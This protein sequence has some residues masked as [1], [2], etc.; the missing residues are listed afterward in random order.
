MNHS[1]VEVGTRRARDGRM[2]N[3]SCTLTYLGWSGFLLRFSRSRP[4][5]FDPPQEAAIPRDEDVCLLVTHGHPEHIAGT[6]AYLRSKTRKGSAEVFASPRI[7][8]ALK[9]RSRNEHDVFHPCRPEQTHGMAGITVNVFQC[10]HM[11]LLPPEKGEG[12]RRLRQVAGNPRLVASIVGDVGRFPLAG[13]LLGFR[14]ASADA[15]S[16]MFY[17]EGLHRCTGRDKVAAVGRRLPSDILITAVEPEDTD[18]MPDLVSAA[19]APVVVPYEAH[20]PWR[21]GFGMPCA[22]LDALS[23]ELRHEGYGIVRA[24]LDTPV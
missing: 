1:T 12:F 11:S 5:L 4:V 6:A 21:E 2:M 20:A 3:R 17:G 16:V 13:P 8:R 14:V 18:I 7:C 15:P 22:D 10:H 23:S 9:R 24:E 19:G